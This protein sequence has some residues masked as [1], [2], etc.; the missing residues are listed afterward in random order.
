MRAL[1]PPLVACGL[2]ASALP[3]RADRPSNVLV[4]LAD[5]LG[6]DGVGVYAEG[7]DLPATPSIDGLAARGLL[8]RNAYA[9]PYCSPSRASFLTGRHPIRHGVAGNSG[10]KWLLPDEVTIPEMLQLAPTTWSSALIGKWHL[11]IKGYQGELFAPN[12]AGFDHYAGELGG[13]TDYFDLLKVTDG[14]ETPVYGKYAAT[15]KVDDAL[16]WTSAAA[17]PWFCTV[18]FNLP[19]KP[20]HAPPAHLHNVPLP[21][22]Y[23]PGVSNPR[24][25]WRAMVEA[26]DTEIGRLL[27]SLPHDL[28]ARTTVVFLGDNGTAAGLAVPPFFASDGKGT[29]YEGGINVP[30]IVA[31]PGVA[32]PGMELDDLVSITDVF[33]TVAEVAGVDLGPAGPL[34][35]VRLDSVSFLP[36]LSSAPGTIQQPREPT[37]RRLAFGEAFF[38]NHVAFPEQL[39]RGLRDRRYKLVHHTTS[40]FS[41]DGPFEEPVYELFDLWADPFERKDLLA[42]PLTPEHQAAFDGLVYALERLVEP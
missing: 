7:V 28:L 19:H 34:A 13:D 18:A 39:K 12:A 38:P 24:P 21:G 30:L 23:V 6:V 16:A 42:A 27:R 35:S 41:I 11:G 8:F 2:L 9:N 17:E 32:A 4:L 10:P 3:A 5:D 14:V 22:P 40:P 20:F 37:A 36:L 26:M 15:D 33:A 25:Y 1:L 29:P 31:G